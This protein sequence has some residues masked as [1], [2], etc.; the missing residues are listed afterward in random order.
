MADTND[1][2]KRAENTQNRKCDL[3]TNSLEKYHFQ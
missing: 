3:E 2:R 1:K